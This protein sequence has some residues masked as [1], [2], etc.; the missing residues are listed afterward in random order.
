MNPESNEIKRGSDRA[1]FSLHDNVPWMRFKTCHVWDSELTFPDSIRGRLWGDPLSTSRT[2]SHE[3]CGEK[4]QIKTNKKTEILYMIKYF[5][6]HC[7]LSPPRLQNSFYTESNISNKY[8]AQ[9]RRCFTRWIQTDQDNISSSSTL[10]FIS[11]FVPTHHLQLLFNDFFSF[12]FFFVCFQYILSFHYFFYFFHLKQKKG[13]Q[14]FFFYFNI[15]Y[16]GLFFHFIFAFWI[17][18]SFLSPPSSYV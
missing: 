10:Y 12:S 15:Q 7:Q 3:E 17:L 8:P 5:I 13:F 11:F 4:Q 14:S 16:F 1:E 9:W 2:L 18:V 6:V